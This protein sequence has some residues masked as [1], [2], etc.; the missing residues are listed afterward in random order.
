[1]NVKDPNTHAAKIKAEIVNGTPIRLA[2]SHYGYSLS[3]NAFLKGTS[4]YL[5]KGQFGSLLVCTIPCTE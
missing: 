2:L 4:L 5:R 1:M 3:K